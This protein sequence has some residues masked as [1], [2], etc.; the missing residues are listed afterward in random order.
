MLLIREL[1]SVEAAAVSM[2]TIQEYAEGVS[3]GRAG[4]GVHGLRARPVLRLWRDR[5]RA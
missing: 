5:Y 1:N 4:A 3:S 2:N